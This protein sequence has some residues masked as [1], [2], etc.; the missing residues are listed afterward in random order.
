MESM[1]YSPWSPHGPYVDCRK[2]SHGLHMSPHGVH[3]NI[4][5]SVKCSIIPLLLN[6]E[7]VKIHFS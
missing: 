5:V 2:Y 3:G 4:W 1:E 6:M 7:T